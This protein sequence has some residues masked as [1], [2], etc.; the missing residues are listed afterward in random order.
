MRAIRP[1]SPGVALFL[2]LFGWYLLTMSGHTYT[3]DEETMLAAGERF[4]TRGSF[5]LPHDFLM[6]SNMGV[7][8]QP[9]SRY[10]PGQSVA[11]VPFILIGK[12]VALAAPPYASGFILRL[13]VLLLPA[14]VTAATALILYH[15]VRTIGYSSRT[16]LLVGLL[17]GLSLAWPYS[18]MFFAEPL[19]TFFLVLCAYSVRRE[20]GVWWAVAGGA[21]ACAIAVKAQSLLILP[22]IAGYALLVCWRGSVR[23]SV[24]PLVGRVGFGLAG[25]A[26]PF[27]LLLLYHTLI[28]GGPFKTGYGG[29]DPMGL[30]DA[31]WR[32]GLYGLTLSTGEGIIV[33]SPTILLGLAGIGFRW[34]QQWR[35]ALLALAVLTVTL[36]FYSRFTAWYGDG[37]WGPR[38][39][40]F[41]LPFAYL[42]MA[43]LLATIA[44]RRVRVGAVLVG[45]L[46][47]LTFLI[48]L[49]PILA[50]YNTYIQI[51][52]THERIVNPAASPLVGHLR[53][54]RERLSEWWLRVAPPPGV[55]VLRDGF[56]YSEGDRSKNEVLPRW[57]YAEATMQIYPYDADDVRSE[58]IRGSIVV[59]DHRPWPLERARFGLRLNGEPLA[60]VEQSDLTGQQITWALQF[61]LAPEMVQQDGAQLTLQ[62]DTW[63][64]DDMTDENPRDEELGVR[65][66]TLAFSQGGKSLAVREALPIPTVKRDRR[67]LWLWYYDTPRHHLFDAWLWYVWV[68]NLPPM[69]VVLLLLLI[70]APAA[71]MVAIGGRGCIRII[72]FECFK[73]TN[74]FSLSG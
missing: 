61:Q 30:L 9:Y 58:P 18:R 33:F 34:R 38:Y 41:A 54:W 8:G 71:V 47:L 14:L 50:N 74:S 63:N 12:L 49:L 26:L 53:L 45:G 1:P 25:L 64:P 2:L 46:V 59:G 11:A 35:E 17:Y 65:V 27:G 21:A 20:Q 37:S 40:F 43:G 60:G 19:A 29:L 69:T 51:S 13:F 70:A 7:D 48:Q 66:E 15:W 67:E 62:S 72:C 39:L 24:S 36:A 16:G 28:F 68:A 22:L 56:S 23:A 73:R 55:V 42:P 4:V 32:E 10:G 6:T 52:D 57:T 31:D 5:A 3:S 44:A